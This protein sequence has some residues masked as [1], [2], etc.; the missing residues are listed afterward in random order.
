MQLRAG[1]E[2]LDERLIC[3]RDGSRY[4]ETPDGQL[5]QVG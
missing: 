1:G 3:P 4:R 5:E 2:R